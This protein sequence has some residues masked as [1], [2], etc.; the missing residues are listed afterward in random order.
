MIFIFMMMCKTMAFQIRAMIL[1]VTKMGKSEMLAQDLGTL[2][3]CAFN[4]K[5]ADLAG[6]VPFFPTCVRRQLGKVK[7][8]ALFLDVSEPWMHCCT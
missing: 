5:V 6:H 7:M 4:P 3:S 8:V 2:F 1:F